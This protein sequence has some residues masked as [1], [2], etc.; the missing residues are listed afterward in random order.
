MAKKRKNEDSTESDTQEKKPKVSEVEL[1][2]TVFKSMLKEP[3]KAKKGLETFISVAKQLPCPGLYDVVEGYI[4]ISMDCAEILKLLEEEKRLE[5]ET[6]L[7]F[8]GLEMIL[9]R[10]ASDL[11]H[12]SMAGIAIVKK[13]VSSFMK[14]ICSV[15]H[16]ENHRY[17]RQCLSLLSAM[18]SQGP[19]SAR[20]VFSNFNFGK[21]L[22]G[23]ARRRDKQGKPDIRLAYIQFAVSFLISGD[24]QTIGQVLETKD[25]LTDIL[26]T[27]LKDDRISSINL[28]LSTLQTKVVQN[29][30][31]SKTQ[32]VRFF[33]SAVLAHIASL[34]K[35]NGIADAI[36][37]ESKMAVDPGEAG[38]MVV[39]ELTHNFLLDLCCSLN[40]GINFYDQS[41]GTAGRSGNVVLLQ[42]IVGLKQATED[43]L[44]AELVVSI[45]KVCPDLL[46]R[47][48]KE[49]Q[50]SFVPRQKTAWKDNINLLKKI[51][52][53]QPEVS[54][55]FSNEEFIPLPRLLS[56][57]MVTSLP[58]IC[59]KAFFTQGLNMGNNA[60]KHTTL[61]LVSFILKRALKNIEYCQLKTVWQNSD[62][63]S[64]S[65]MEDFVQQYR[66]A[67]SKVLPD[68]TNIVAT[69]QSLTKKEKGEEGDL[70]DERK[71]ESENLEGFDDPETTILKAVILKVICLYQKVVPHLIS[72]STFDFS[73]LLKG[74]VTEKG[75]REEVAPVLQYQML[76]L[77]LDLPASKFSWFRA[78]EAVDPGRASGEKS[79][80]YLLLKMFVTSSN[81]HLKTSTRM[82]VVKVLK[83]S[84]VFEYTWQE[85]ELWL[86][87][88]A[89]VQQSEQ[90]TVIQ[91]L[92][93]VLVKLV[94]NPYLYT[95]KAASLVQEASYLQANLTGQ[96]G[97]AASIPVSHIDDVL[98]M[99]DVIME[100]S[101]G[102]C[103][104][105]GSALNE[106]LILQTFPFS[107]LVP[108]ALEARNRLPAISEKEHGMHGVVPEFLIAVLSDVLHSQRD[109]LPLCLALQQY[110]KELVSAEDSTA[111]PPAIV[112]FYRYYSLWIP[113]QARE[114]LFKSSDF[115][116]PDPP[117]APGSFSCLM[118]AAYSRGATYMLQDSFKESVESAVS[119]LHTSD[120][121]VAVKHV[122]LYIKTCV[123][124]FGMF[125]KDTGIVLLNVYMDLLRTLINR[126]QC[127]EETGEAVSSNSQDESDL[128]VDVNTAQ[129]EKA[130]KD[131]VL[132]AVLK[133]IFS[134]PTLEQWFLAVELESL[135]PH[136]L[137]PIKS[138]KLCT[139]ISSNI[140]S[141][142]KLTAQLMEN[143]G[144]L[145]LTS[146]YLAG[147]EKAVLK[148]METAKLRSSARRTNK[149]SH[150]IEGL[151]EFHKYMEPARL[152]EIVSAILLLPQEFLVVAGKHGFPEE[153]SVYAQSA[154]QVLTESSQEDSVFVSHEHFRG[155]GTLLLSCCSEPLEIFLLK[156]LQTEPVCS[157]L[158]QTDILI[159]CLQR[160]THTCQA[161]GALLLQTCATHRLR[162]ELW[163]LE[164][165]SMKQVEKHFE[166]FLPL[167]KVYLEMPSC[168]DPMRP[169]EVHAAVLR[170]LKE[171]LLVK[172]LDMVLSG[173][174][175]QALAL[176]VDV[177]S[178]LIKLAAQV[179]DL[180]GAADRLSSLLESV[181]S[182]E[183][184]MLVDSITEGLAGA[185][186]TQASWKRSL[187]TASF[188]WLKAS[189]TKY[190][191]QEQAVQ[192]KEEK[193]LQ[194]LQ[195]LLGSVKQVTASDWNSFVK[196]G[197][198]YRYRDQVFLENL[199]NLLVLVYEAIDSSKDLVE[200]GTVH[201]MVTSHS[202]FL[203]TLLPA[204]EEQNGT[205]DALVTVLLTLVKKCPGVCSSAHFSVLMGAYGATLSTTDQKM[206]Q[207]LQEYER[208]GV[209][210]AE[211]QSLLWGPAAVEH[212]KASRNLGSSLW[213]QPTSQDVLALLKPDKMLH[214]ALHFPEQRQIIPQDEEELLFTDKR[215]GDLSALY[216]PCFL[217][218]LFSVLLKPECVVDCYKFVSC[219]AFGVTVAALSSYDPH[220]RAAAYQ[221]LGQFYHHLDGAR[222]KERRQLL[223]L[224]DAVR[225]GI[226]QPNV[227]LPF[228][229]VAY[230]SRVA[231]QMLKPE[232][233]M[234][235]VLNKFLLSHQYLDLQKVPC[236][237]KLF[238]SFDLEH[239]VERHWLLGFLVEGL[240]DKNCYELCDRQGVFQILLSYCSNPICEESVQIQILDVLQ[241]AA[242]VTK[243]AY[244][245]IKCHG[246][247]TWILQV[248]E[249][250][251]IES[252]ILSSLISLVHTLWFTNLGD[253]E[254]R[255]VH[256]AADETPPKTLKCLPLPLIDEFVR[257]LLAFIRH[258][259]TGSK[260]LQLAQ[261]LQTLSSVLTHRSTALGTYREKGHMTLKERTLSCTEALI[262]L[263]KWSTTAKD[264]PILNAIHSV[265]HKHK[266]KELLKTSK[267]RTRGKGFSLQ[268]QG[269]LGEK[270]DE[271][272]AAG[273]QDQ[274]PLPTCE[275]FLRSIFC[276]WEPAI[277]PG[278]HPSDGPAPTAQLGPTSSVADSE[279]LAGATAHLLV[280]WG[281]KSLVTAPLDPSDLHK[282]LQWIHSSVLPFP[283]V[284]GALLQDSAAKHNF[285]R[286]YHQACENLH[287]VGV[288]GVHLFTSIMTR[289][290]EAQG[291]PSGALYQTTLK[292]CFPDSTHVDESRRE[293][294]LLLMSQYIL[295]LWTGAQEPTLFLTHVKLVTQTKETGRARTLKK[296]EHGTSQ[297]AVFSICKELSVAL[298]SSV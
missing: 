288:G 182:F 210:L 12:F 141:L 297:A 227:R 63:Y 284:V 2:G 266:V 278:P 132:G 101:E 144:S 65:M 90:E 50:Y 223:Y 127:L 224:M 225:N 118:K 135:P 122:L 202:L 16:S 98:D 43:E 70:K 255:A 55:A 147:I 272:M 82:L 15:L 84:G 296:K 171:A 88:L 180:A 155:L 231:Q 71:K 114:E 158:V 51:Y 178:G 78:Q 277:L 134:H 220:V 187:L 248:L 123:D 27:G 29:K 48:F 267:E 254:S 205:K 36:P 273:I 295:E 67:L 17:V 290:L 59:N 68:L 233:H 275:Q 230:I 164:P 199:N 174:P 124:N 161:I 26:S 18:V 268:S 76:Q 192:E 285:L 241:Q 252:R 154:L 47:Y 238:Y 287:S 95:D 66:E 3:T 75:M 94:S 80:F 250:R 34:Y 130:E 53:A 294:G 49:T 139:Q 24:N 165:G 97:D 229:L 41:L 92:E 169:K 62:V 264:T 279:G 86:D 292:V 265:A 274:P 271:L 196:T 113:P 119:K 198:K 262:L 258:I 228:L 193:M 33:S 236:F 188:K 35:W 120:L 100:G 168:Q 240:K 133:S 177:L 30:A 186:Q 23:L 148:E 108:A 175:A 115:P 208:N 74:I 166:A 209:S 37:E 179:E 235:V 102:E 7:I 13:I 64:V 79:V 106:D 87:H 31:I 10:T 261:F 203:S 170:D 283:G 6:A 143:L 125:S 110:D 189:Y 38:R 152:K 197:L 163:C 69:W 105:L 247:L 44:V 172:L 93:R 213:Q 194:Q 289:L 42:F 60:V 14:I 239:K 72:Q 185:P 222:F 112:E 195:R 253:K 246:L 11:S 259:Q 39:R 96:E 32:K 138:K 237:F 111:T 156:A 103:E 270:A 73:K 121:P 89:L 22:S 160:L 157:K 200:L 77:A 242:H 183:R 212:H 291:C 58:F 46:Q 286:L 269:R 83:D 244:E 257:L 162:F 243:A 61:S 140:L 217:L 167:V 204:E 249:K 298:G 137:N 184:W 215:I 85:L 245:L 40:H 280:K 151:M 173:S 56:M 19:D 219:N 107:A 146:K 129:D 45:L 191:E 116:S 159:Y 131:L 145:D 176:Q 28:L 293:A 263:H 232:E 251:F 91:F 260:A 276:S 8:Q 54:R 99:V 117:S 201:M 153:L 216:D 126:L 218:P 25:F 128:F 150:P 9:L 109:P 104:E 211:F 21:S 214:T 256:S 281:L 234:Y 57:V 221:V 207:L 81:T 282:F 52:E 142:L 20:E 149:R 1:N 181:D 190:K 206:L 226:R 5:S 136:N 4:K